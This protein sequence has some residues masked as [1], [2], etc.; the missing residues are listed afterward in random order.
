MAKDNK[1]KDQDNKE[2]KKQL[3]PI[4]TLV[5]AVVIVFAILFAFLQVLSKDDG[6]DQGQTT[7]VPTVTQPDDRSAQGGNAPSQGMGDNGDKTPQG[8]VAPT[9]GRG[10]PPSSPD[11]PS[12]NDPRFGPPDFLAKSAMYQI[13]SMDITPGSS[14]ESHFNE[15]APIFA[16]KE[17]Q[18]KG[19]VKWYSG[20]DHSPGWPKAGNDRLIAF[21]SNSD[22]KLTS[23]DTY[24]V[25]LVV[26]QRLMTS[27]PKGYSNLPEFQVQAEMKFKNDKW[28]LNGWQYINGTTPNIH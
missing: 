9:G 18:Q 6:S 10:N 11:H 5:L 17:M 19:F 3:I 7:T 28:L 25:N 16:T 20:N 4:I 22:G 26:N 27:K 15:V 13:F 23:K 24:V 1:K 12:P 14:Y 2:K 21:V 8:D